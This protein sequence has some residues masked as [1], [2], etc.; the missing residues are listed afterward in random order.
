LESINNIFHFREIHLISMIIH[1]DTKPS[2]CSIFHLVEDHTRGIPVRNLAKGQVI[3]AP[4][5]SAK[6][7][8]PFQEQLGII[9]GGVFCTWKSLSKTLGS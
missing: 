8:K 3:P 6:Y 5:C 7:F 2:H 9:K 1:Q 4:S